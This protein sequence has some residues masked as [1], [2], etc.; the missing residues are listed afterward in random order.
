MYESHEL[1]P[2]AKH[3]AAHAL[4]GHLVCHRVDGIRVS[5]KGA[6]TILVYPV[7]TATLPR[8]FSDNPSLACLRL[9]ELT[10]PIYAFGLCS[11]G[12]LAHPM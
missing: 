4:H 9:A 2:L 1:Y 3:E 6:H 11:C 8:Q 10:F 12:F 5:R 7:S